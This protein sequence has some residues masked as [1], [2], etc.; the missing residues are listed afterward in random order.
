[1]FTHR[2]TLHRRWRRWQRPAA[3]T[4]A[5][6]AALLLLA[7]APTVDGGPTRAVVVASAE[8]PAGHTLTAADLVVRQWPAGVV[9]GDAPADPEELVG[10]RTAGPIAVGEPVLRLRTVGPDLLTAAGALPGSVG[11]VLPLP[12]GSGAEVFRPGDRVDVFAPI[13]RGLSG[14]M[15]AGNS[16]VLAIDDNRIV[17]A[18][19]GQAAA[20]VAANPM[21]DQLLIALR[22]S[23]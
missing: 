7:V 2:W 4:L 19:S 22:P 11:V 15:V 17:L 14:R 16:L 8:L 10:R 18:V 5:A 6:L 23:R 3:A 9:P 1:M 21:A 13:G 12:D 20:T